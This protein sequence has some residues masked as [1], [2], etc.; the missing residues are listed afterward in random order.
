MIRVI[1]A[2]A[3]YP[4]TRAQAKEWCRVDADDSSQDNVLDLLIGA[5]T[6]YAEHLTGRAFVERT[7][8]LTA[9]ATLVGLAS[10]LLAKISKP[11][12]RVI[13]AEEVKALREI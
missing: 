7:L 8:E 3:S 1:T 13:D 4:V 11:Q 12:E 9:D 6:N 5:M 2:P 10:D